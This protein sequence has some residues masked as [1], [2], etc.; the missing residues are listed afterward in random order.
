MDDTTV[1]NLIPHRL[2]I[3]HDDA[4]T[5]SIEQRTEPARLVERRTAAAPVIINQIVV[6][7]FRIAYADTVTNI[8]DPVD[9]VVLVVSRVTAQAL[10]TRSDLFFPLDE[11][12]DEQQRIIGCRALGTFA[13][14]PEYDPGG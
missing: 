11:V 14:A 3:Y 4:V 1:V 12:R 9:G 2:Q 10:P 5:V 13:S 8:P 6:P 7:V